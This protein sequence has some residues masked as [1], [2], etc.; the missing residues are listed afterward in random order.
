MKAVIRTIMS[1][2][3]P[4]LASWRPSDADFGLHVR[5]L[6]GP[7]GEEGEESFDLTVCTA[8]W[9]REEARG[10]K[11]MDLRHHLLVESFDWPAVEAY[12]TRRVS[13]C[14]GDTWQ[15]VA[16]CVGRIGHW[17]FEDYDDRATC[18]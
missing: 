5:L 18:G 6:V 13:G 17:E 9:L 4:D 14:E 16:E 8:G 2:D 10:Q 15:A 1:V 3:I 12:V 11:V 7:A